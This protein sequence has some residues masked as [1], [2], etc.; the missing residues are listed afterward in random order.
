MNCQSSP[1]RLTKLSPNHIDV[2]G[3]HKRGI[4][5]AKSR[6]ETGTNRDVGGSSGVVRG[7][8]GAHLDAGLVPRAARKCLQG[9]QHGTF[10]GHLRSQ[11]GVARLLLVHRPAT[12]T[13][14]IRARLGLESR[15]PTISGH[16]IPVSWF[17]GILAKEPSLHEDFRAS[18]AGVPNVA[19]AACNIALVPPDRIA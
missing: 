18:L 12:G 16:T 1:I 14:G 17:E 7:S 19:S 13:T 15:H 4:A 6:T 8:A 11:Q 5:S 2:H 10:T 3:R 9:S